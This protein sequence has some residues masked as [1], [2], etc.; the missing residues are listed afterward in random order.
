MAASRVP[1]LSSGSRLAHRPKLLPPFRH[2][3]PFRSIIPLAPFRTSAAPPTI[4]HRTALQMANKTVRRGGGR[5]A[6]QIAVS[7]ARSIGDA[8]QLRVSASP[9]QLGI[10][11]GCTTRGGRCLSSAARWCPRPREQMASRARSQ[12]ATASPLACVFCFSSTGSRVSESSGEKEQRY[13]A[14][15]KPR[16]KGKRPTYL[17]TRLYHGARLR[18]A[19]MVRRARS[20]GRQ[21]RVTGV[22]EQSPDD[23]TQRRKE[24][25][26][27]TVVRRIRATVR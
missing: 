1:R 10:F 27:R 8:S 9:A 2:G 16:A 12:P 15:D 14:R 18:R 20:K 25:W 11:Q 21:G 3:S 26:D 24:R 7:V 6:T 23:E 4:I 22:E 5:P 17:T 19:T 13:S